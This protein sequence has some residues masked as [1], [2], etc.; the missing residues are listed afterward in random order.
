MHECWNCGQSC[1]CDG[2]DHD[3]DQPDDCA[4]PCWGADTPQEGTP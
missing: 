3:Q 1:D 4:C 2:E